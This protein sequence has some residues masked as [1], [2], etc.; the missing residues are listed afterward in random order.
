MTSEVLETSEVCCQVG[1]ASHHRDGRVSVRPGGDISDLGERERPVDRLDAKPLPILG[2]RG[3]V[4]GALPL[5]ILFEGNSAE[6]RRVR[7]EGGEG[8]EVVL[9]PAGDAARPAVL[10]VS[11][12]QLAE[13]G[14]VVRVFGIGEE[15]G[16]VGAALRGVR[17]LEGL[18]E[19]VDL[20]PG[21][22]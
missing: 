8:G 21:G 1:R 4:A 2:G 20:F 14:Q 10:D 22:W 13:Y 5:A 11:A 19:R 12:H 7:A 3:V 17:P 16:D 15:V 18:D 6:A 9:G